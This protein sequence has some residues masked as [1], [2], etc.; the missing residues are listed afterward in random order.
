MKAS[1]F[2]AAFNAIAINPVNVI[3]FDKEWYNGT[4]YLDHATQLVQLA[5]NGRAVSTTTGGRKIIFIGTKLGTV[6]VFERYTGNE[7]RDD[8]IVVSNTPPS[9]VTCLEPGAMSDDGFESAVGRDW[10]DI[11]DP[12]LAL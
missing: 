7:G 2:N 6:A 1:I 10:T 8:I 3:E 4:G 5:P 9:M 12:A 11:G